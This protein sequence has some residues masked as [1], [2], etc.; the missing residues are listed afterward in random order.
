[1]KK[2]LIIFGAIS[3]IVWFGIALLFDK[4]VEDYNYPVIPT[5]SLQACVGSFLAAVATGILIALLFQK[6]LFK[7]SKRSLFLAPFKIMPVAITAFGLLI[8][9][10]WIFLGEAD[11]GYYSLDYILSIFL[12]YGLFG[13]LTAPFVYGF[14]V[15]NLLVFRKYM[16][17]MAP[18]RV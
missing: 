12:I 17:P 15:I 1:M 6:S 9:L 8:K 2:Q 13:P 10:L 4:G 3:G 16:V 7:T 18:T 14:T 5:N 11:N